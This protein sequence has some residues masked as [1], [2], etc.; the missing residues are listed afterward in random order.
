MH[1]HKEIWFISR[2]VGS[3]MLVTKDRIIGSN[4]WRKLRKTVMEEAMS[5]KEIT[6]KEYDLSNA[7][8]ATLGMICVKMKYYMFQHK[9]TEKK[10]RSRKWE[11]IIF[12]T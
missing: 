8:S 2:G 9:K 4:R 12:K 5:M 3:M 7:Q 6:R 1:Y 10:Y 11:N